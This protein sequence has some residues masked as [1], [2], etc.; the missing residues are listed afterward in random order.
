MYILSNRRS[1]SAVL[2]CIFAFCC[3][4]FIEPIL[5][6]RLISLG[7]TEMNVGLAFAAIGLAVIVA[8]PIAGY[9]AEKFKTTYVF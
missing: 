3:T 5:A 2:I 7:M 9:L 4:C 8:S 1:L 6:V